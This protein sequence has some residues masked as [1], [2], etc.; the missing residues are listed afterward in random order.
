MVEYNI[1]SDKVIDMFGDSV[2]KHADLIS[3]IYSMHCEFWKSQTAGQKPELRVQHLQQSDEYVLTIRGGVGID[4]RALTDS[5]MQE[6]HLD[7]KCRSIVVDT[8]K[9]L[10]RYTISAS[11]DKATY[12]FA[13]APV[14]STMPTVV[15]K[16]NNSRS[17]VMLAQKLSHRRMQRAIQL[18][19]HSGRQIPEFDVFLNTPH[20]GDYIVMTI[21]NVIQTS[22][23]FIFGLLHDSIAN[24]ARIQFCPVTD[25]QRVFELR[26]WF[27]CLHQ[28]D[29]ARNMGNEAAPKRKNRISRFV[30]SF[31]NP[32]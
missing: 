23:R 2:K 11:G 6:V 10:T 17:S 27:E 8:S 32:Y 18:Y 15:M 5:K 13:S 19:T 28:N 14:C 21:N 22:T 9:D 30:Q 20:D 26:M 24:I 12:A 4:T 3:A 7:T 25:D 16:H 31:C 1:T 29:S